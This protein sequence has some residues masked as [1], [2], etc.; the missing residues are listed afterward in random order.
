M[1]FL[2]PLLFILTIT[3]TDSSKNKVIDMPKE[4]TLAN[5]D[6]DAVKISK[7]FDASGYS[8]NYPKLQ[9]TD[10]EKKS[11]ELV[12]KNVEIPSSEIER[13]KMISVVALNF[14]DEMSEARRREYDAFRIKI[15]NKNEYLDGSYFKNDI[16]WA[17]LLSKIVDGFFQQEKDSIPF[18]VLDPRFYPESSHYEIRKH[19]DNLLP[20][21]EPRTMKITGFDT[22][23]INETGEDVVLY[24]AELKGRVKTLHF[25]FCVSKKTD[26]IIDLVIN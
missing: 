5:G 6:S 22:K 20:R 13:N 10:G 4:D 24:S 16:A 26:Q 14:F 23:T 9:T 8:V 11:I 12:L 7:I 3:C 2:F 21:A 18:L 19:I 1:R 17:S 15:V 25:G